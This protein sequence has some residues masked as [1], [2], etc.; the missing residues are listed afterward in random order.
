MHLLCIN[1][2]FTFQFNETIFVVA[3]ARK[4]G[5][6]TVRREELYSTYHITQER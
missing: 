1:Y 4:T 2:I 6:V 3:K 5:E